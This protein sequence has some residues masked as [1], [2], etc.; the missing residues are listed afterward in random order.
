MLKRLLSVVL[1]LVMAIGL[2]LV[3]PV[4]A[5]NGQEDM[6][7]GE[8]FI[9]DVYVAEAFAVEAFATEMSGV[10]A[11]TQALPNVPPFIVRSY[12]IF[13]RE[14]ALYDSE[15]DVYRMFHEVVYSELRKFTTF[16]YGQMYFGFLELTGTHRNPWV[17]TGFSNEYRRRHYGKYCGNMYFVPF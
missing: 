7:A 3:A 16:A 13:D 12:T 2:V 15:R 6:N 17:W 5:Q 8:L 9:Q 4:Y 1:S 10:V 14:Y 11:T